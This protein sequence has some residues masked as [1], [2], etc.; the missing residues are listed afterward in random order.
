MAKIRRDVSLRKTVSQ[1]KLPRYEK[2]AKV[3]KRQQT[4]I[5]HMFMY[6]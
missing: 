2:F 3:D 1:F 6:V 5:S 4:P